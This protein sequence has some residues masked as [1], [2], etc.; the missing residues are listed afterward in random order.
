VWASSTK[1]NTDAVLWMQSDGNLILY[2]TDTRPLMMSNT[3]GNPD[4]TLIVQGDGNLVIY[5]P[6]NRAI[7]WSNR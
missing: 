1:G 6:G 3:A 5:A 4:S 7:W 2:G